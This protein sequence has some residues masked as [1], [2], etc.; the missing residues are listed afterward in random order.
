MFS[1]HLV[2][3]AS[4]VYGM[5]DK[6]Y[7]FTLLSVLIVAECKEG[8]PVSPERAEDPDQDPKDILYEMQLR[9]CNR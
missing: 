7:S 6:F 4:F 2:K 1:F 8:D 9:R 5:L 3:N